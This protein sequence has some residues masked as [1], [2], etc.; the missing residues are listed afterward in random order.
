M[1]KRQSFLE[2]PFTFDIQRLN[3][4]L[5][6]A[7]S[8]DWISHPNINAYNGSW[9]VSS[10]TAINGDTKQIIAIEN[11]DY[12]DTPLMKKT[13]YIK[14]IL[15]TFKTK[16]EAVRF[17]NLGA[18]SI[19]KEHCDNGS[20][21]ED[22]YARLH[23]PISTNDDV[24][25]ILNSQ[26]YKM[27]VGKCYYIDAHNPHSVINKGKNDRVHL[28][29]D[30][31]VNDYLKEIFINNGFVLPVYKYGSKDITDE[32]VDDIIFSFK[33]INTEVSLKMA[34]ELEDK[35]DSNVS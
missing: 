27:E 16:I 34:Q 12:Y 18:N 26:N 17:M 7:K 20:C 11:Q 24:A 25:F 15:D 22:G 9:S 8:D 3:D 32:N 13:K 19:I 33:A 4:D 28:L 35:K 29:I 1:S 10:L 6:C 31:H 2:L 23:I 14:S 5:N 30:C 21:F